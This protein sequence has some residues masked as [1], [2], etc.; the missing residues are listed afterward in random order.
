MILL[1]RGG[2]KEAILACKD[3]TYSESFVSSAA[4][5]WS[6]TQMSLYNGVDARHQMNSKK[7]RPIGCWDCGRKI[8]YM[9]PAEARGFPVKSGVRCNYLPKLNRAVNSPQTKR[10]C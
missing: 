8:E 3:A 1:G 2:V 10:Y 6:G 4:S 7:I 5:T 9:K